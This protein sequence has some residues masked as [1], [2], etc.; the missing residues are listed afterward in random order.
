MDASPVMEDASP[1]ESHR[2]QWTDVSFHMAV[3]P[4]GIDFSVTSAGRVGAGD[5][6]HPYLE[7]LGCHTSAMNCCHP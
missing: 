7:S 6:P 2:L 5:G 4:L 1:L 3:G